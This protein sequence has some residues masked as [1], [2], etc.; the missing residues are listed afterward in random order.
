MT[1]TRP[2]AHRLEI[3]DGDQRVRVMLDGVVLADSERPVVL[4]EGSLPARYYLPLEDVR[5]EL[6]T[7]TDTSSHCPFKGDATYW[8]AEG[9]AD[10]AWTYRT[11]VAGAERI[12]GR[13]CFFNEKVDLEIDGVVQE[14]P[15]TRW[16]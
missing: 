11:P 3:V 10:V 14:R 5:M 2:D 16:S 9:A 1:E 6:L 13:V 15:K 7:P 4:R 8:S 12:A